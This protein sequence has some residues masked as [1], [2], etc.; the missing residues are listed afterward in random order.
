M[1]VGSTNQVFFKAFTLG[2]HECN[3]RL[4]EQKSQ[5]LLWW[6]DRTAYIWRPVSDFRLR[7]D[8][9]FPEWLQSHTRFGD[10]AIL[11]AK[12]SANLAHV[13]DGCRQ[14]HCI[15]NCGQKAADRDMVIALSNGIANSLRRTI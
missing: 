10:V 9:D 1:L 7:K 6:A 2:V 4:R 11:D 13:S 12:I 3:M 5:L 15:P 14:K 8:S